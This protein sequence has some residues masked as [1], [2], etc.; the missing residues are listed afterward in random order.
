MERIAKKV[1]ELQNNDSLDALLKSLKKQEQQKL[2]F[3]DE[4]E[5]RESVE[6]TVNDIE[7]NRVHS[8]RWVLSEHGHLPQTGIEPVRSLTLAGF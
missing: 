1:V 3:F 6:L 8:N 2:Y 4:N 5:N 7:K